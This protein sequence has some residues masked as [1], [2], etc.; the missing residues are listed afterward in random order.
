MNKH[1]SAVERFV[2]NNTLL[3]PMASVDVL[4]HVVVFFENSIPPQKI[5]YF[6]KRCAHLR[7]SG[8]RT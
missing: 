2:Q 3:L 5:V 8:F 6:D 1:K 4:Q 7:L